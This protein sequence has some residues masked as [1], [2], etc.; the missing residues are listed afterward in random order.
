MSAWWRLEF[1]GS[2]PVPISI[3]QAVEIS[4]GWPSGRFLSLKY[5]SVPTSNVS[6]QRILFACGHFVVPDTTHQ[7]ESLIVKVVTQRYSKHPSLNRSLHYFQHF[8]LCL[9]QWPF[10]LPHTIAFNKVVLR[11]WAQPPG[12]LI[13]LVMLWN[14]KPGGPLAR[15]CGAYSLS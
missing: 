8:F 7:T 6:R 14:E 9:R 2:T 3:E 1:T 10:F 4:V 12:S 5:H 11:R 15:E 13:T